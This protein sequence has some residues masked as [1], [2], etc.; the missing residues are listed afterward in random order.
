M[1]FVFQ[2]NGSNSPTGTAESAGDVLRI[3]TLVVQ[4][5]NCLNFGRGEFR[6]AHAGDE[7]SMNDAGRCGSANAESAAQEAEIFA[8]ATP[9]KS[10]QLKLFYFAQYWGPALAGFRLLPTDNRGGRL[11]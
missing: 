2:Q 4:V 10:E 1:I 6:L 11:V 7:C 8:F 5:E 3:D 9:V